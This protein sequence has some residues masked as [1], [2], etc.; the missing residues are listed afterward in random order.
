MKW[1]I[2]HPG[3]VLC[4]GILVSLVFSSTYIDDARAQQVSVANPPNISGFNDHISQYMT[5]HEAAV[6]K[7]PKPGKEAKPDKIEIYQEGLADSIRGSRVNAKQG[8][9][10]TPQVASQFRQIIKAELKGQALKETRAEAN[11]P[12]VKDVPVRVNYPYPETKEL[13]DTPPTLLIKL[14]QLPKQLG[15]HF[16]R[17]NLLLIDREARIIVDYI[18]NALP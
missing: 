12:E 15:Y 1:N 10:F 8:D 16:A 7:L 4:A 13:L 9:V 6:K 18:P 5:L 17:K 11:G 2:R 14:P 3:I